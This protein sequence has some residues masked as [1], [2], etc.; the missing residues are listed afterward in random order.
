MQRDGPSRVARLRGP[1]A[2]LALSLVVA[3]HSVP[4]APLADVEPLAVLTCCAA[5]CSHPQA[6]A[7]GCPCC[8]VPSDTSA[9]ARLVPRGAAPEGITAAAGVSTGEPCRDVSELALHR[10]IG[11]P[12]PPTFLRLCRLQR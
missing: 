9:P 8:Q 10:V 2:S 5:H 11:G 4:A 12:A 1:G 6:A 3:V 7:H